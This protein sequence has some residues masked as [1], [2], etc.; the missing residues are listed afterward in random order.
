MKQHDITAI[1]PLTSSIT[2]IRLTPQHKPLQHQAGQYIEIESQA[3]QCIP[4]SIANAPRDDGSLDFYIRHL[5]EDTDAIILLEHLTSAEHAT[6]LGPFG[7][8]I[9]HAKPNLPILFLAGGTGFSQI[10]AM[11]EQAIIND[12]Q[13]AMELY[14]GLRHQEDI[15]LQAL[16]DEWQ[17]KLNFKYHITLRDEGYPQETLLA[18]H[19]DLTNKIIYSSGPWSM[20]DSALALFLKHGM[21]RE[22]MHSDRFAF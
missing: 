13:R 15:F 21:K 1:Q 3:Q 18:N 4:L 16:L 19:P 10:K 22:N 12:D 14:W 9:L 6:I 5:P 2:F 17:E 7:N 11:I 8:C 20:T